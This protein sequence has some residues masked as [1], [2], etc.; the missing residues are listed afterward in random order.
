MKAIRATWEI[1]MESLKRTPFLILRLKSK[2]C[3]IV[4]KTGGTGDHQT[5]VAKLKGKLAIAQGKIAIAMP[6]F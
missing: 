2:F 3:R 6:R 5:C 1:S 4:Q